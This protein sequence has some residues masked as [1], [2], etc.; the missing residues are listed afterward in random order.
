MTL[1]GLAPMPALAQAPAPSSKSEA[2]P[3]L[4]T[5]D[6]E[7]KWPI[8][9]TVSNASHL[10]EVPEADDNEEGFV[11]ETENFH[12]VSPIALNKKARER[13]ARIFECSLAAN[14]AL[15]DLLPIR[16]MHLRAQQDEKEK[17]DRMA[18]K[19]EDKEFK[20]KKK[21][22]GGQIYLTY[23]DY[24]QAGG[25]EGSNGLYV[26]KAFHF[27][28]EAGLIDD[29]VLIPIEALGINK[30]GTLMKK[31]IETQVLVHEI[32][33]QC[34]VLNNLPIWVNEGLADYVGGISTKGSNLN[35]STCPKDIAARSMHLPLSKCPFTLEELFGMSQAEFYKY[36]GTDIYLY[37]VSA[38]I[39]SYFM[40]MNGKSGRARLCAYLDALIEG[41]PPKE[42]AELLLD[43]KKKQTF[44][45]LEADIE[46]KLKK[47][48]VAV[49]FDA[50]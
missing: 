40:D 49:E 50:A 13:L 20:T 32:T 30:D 45:Q 43:K 5:N 31:E 14:M 4:K 38:G 24:I 42:A 27:R 22:L 21:K 41:T 28:D 26:H 25:R 19:K 18:A 6:P 1:L 36:M 34:F 10:E 29:R 3:A 47:I 15:S 23:K 16:R 37:N 39:I 35:F 7:F 44:E 11:Y 2:T 12:F 8:R 48:K 33:H 17:P 9:F 46:K